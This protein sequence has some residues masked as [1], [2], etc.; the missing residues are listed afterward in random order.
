MKRPGRPQEGPRGAAMTTLVWSSD[1]WTAAPRARGW[2][3]VLVSAPGGLDLEPAALP[4]DVGDLSGLRREDDTAMNARDTA[5]EYLSRGWAPIPIPGATRIQAMPGGST[6]ASPL[7]LSGP[8]STVCAKTSECCSASLVTGWS[9]SISMS[10]RPCKL[11]N[12]LAGHRLH[13]RAQRQ[14]GLPHLFVSKVATKKFVEPRR[15]DG[16][17]GAMLVELQSTGCHAL[18]LAA[19]TPRVS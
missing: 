1:A 2:R 7:R 16:N 10:P 12:P 19:P 15:P 11:S 4:G 18:S 13:L 14:P 6:C 9:M 3:A 5:T 8:T 17:E